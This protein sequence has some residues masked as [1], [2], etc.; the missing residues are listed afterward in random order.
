MAY[1]APSIPAPGR[2]SRAPGGP[3]GLSGVQRREIKR[4]FEALLYLS[5]ALIIF[6]AF[7]F[8]PLVKSI[9]LSTF[10]TNPI[11]VPTVFAGLLNYQRLL[12]TPVFLNSLQRSVQFVLYTVPTT[13][14]VS[15]VLALLGNLRLR[16][17][18]IFRMVFSCTI[19][20]S[21]ATAALIFKQLYHPALGQLNYIF[22]SARHPR[23][24]SG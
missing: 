1:Q 17:I 10:L 2:I 12:E 19:A 5:P 15:M 9:R 14:V 7:V 11:G 20:V 8:I 18:D 4:F 21:G 13:L 6:A 23:R 24:C 22:E 16:R 3:F